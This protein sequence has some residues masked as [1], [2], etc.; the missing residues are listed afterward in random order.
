MIWCRK[1]LVLWVA[2]LDY[3]VVLLNE[4]NACAIAP[5]HLFGM[6]TPDFDKTFRKYLGLLSELPSSTDRRETEFARVSSHRRAMRAW[7]FGP[8]RQAHRPTD[9]QDAVR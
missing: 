8:H 1:A 6:E 5:I 9:K 7:T 4:W 3:Q 2:C